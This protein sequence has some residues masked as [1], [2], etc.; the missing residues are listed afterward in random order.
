MFRQPILEN[1]TSCQKQLVNPIIY[2]VV[3]SL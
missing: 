1:K 2:L 3:F